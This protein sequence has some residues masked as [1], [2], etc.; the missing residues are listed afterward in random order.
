MV[1]AIAAS[2]DDDVG[3]V[4]RAASRWAHNE[5]IDFKLLILLPGRALHLAAGAPDRGPGR[6]AGLSGADELSEVAASG[7]PDWGLSRAD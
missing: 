3:A 4:K 2:D 5:P 6:R 7:R 1:A